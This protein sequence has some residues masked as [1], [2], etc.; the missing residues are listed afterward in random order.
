MVLKCNSK[1]LSY[2]IDGGFRLKQGVAST[3]ACVQ[4][5]FTFANFMW[6]NVLIDKQYLVTKCRYWLLQKPVAMQVHFP[7]CF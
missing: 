5:T 3:H 2:Y 6:C 7:A 1:Y 4:Q